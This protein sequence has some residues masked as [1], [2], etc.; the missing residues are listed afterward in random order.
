MKL[1]KYRA[2]KV[3]AVALVVRE[4]SSGKIEFDKGTATKLSAMDPKPTANV[5]VRL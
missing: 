4:A 3:K 5:T 1:Y 2:C